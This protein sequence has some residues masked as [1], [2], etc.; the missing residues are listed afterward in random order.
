M[1]YTTQMDAAR[2]KIITKE[3][4]KV[5][6]KEGKAVEELRKLIAIGTF[7]I[8]AN[9][10]HTS[11][12]PEGI[13]QGLKTKINVNL[14]IS[15]DCDN[16][17]AELVKVKKAIEM[18]AEAIMDLSSYG[19]THDFRKKLI[20]ISPAMIGTVPIYDAVGFYDKDLKNITAKEFIDVVLEH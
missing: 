20:E 5:A 7:I 3:M 8:P 19:K 15:K 1:T 14:G 13:G 9:K 16:F 2:K 4:E 11:L 18:K 17:D 6:L 12:D 10:N